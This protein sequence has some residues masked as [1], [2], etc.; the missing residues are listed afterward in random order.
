MTG[1]QHMSPDS[2]SCKAY[3]RLSFEILINT[4]SHHSSLHPSRK[5][6]FHYKY[7]ERLDLSHQAFFFMSQQQRPMYQSI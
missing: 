2:T 6:H 7:V 5:Q 1:A 3:D 4:S